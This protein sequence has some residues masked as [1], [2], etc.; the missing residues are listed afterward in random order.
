M[1]ETNKKNYFV[2][3]NVLIDSP[4]CI[5]QLRNG[6]ENNVYISHFVM[7]E[8]NKLAREPRVS[9]LVEKAIDEI[10]KNEEFIHFLQPVLEEE[11]HSIPSSLKD[12]LVDDLILKEIMIEIEKSK[13]PDPILVSNDRIFRRIA[14]TAG[15]RAEPFR[16]SNPF[17]SESETYT[18]LVNPDKG[19]ELI[20]NCFYWRE[21]K[22]YFHPAKGPDKRV[23]YKNEVWNIEPLNEYQNLA[24][25]I[26]LNEEIPIFSMQ[27]SAGY[28]KTFLALAAAFKLVFQDK[29]Y[30]K[31]II[32]KPYE[33]V[34]RSMGFLPGDDQEKMAPYIRNLRDLALKL[35]GIRP[36]NKAFIDPKAPDLEFNPRR[37]EILPLAYI[38]G[39][40]IDDAVFILD[41]IQNLSRQETRAILTRMGQNVKFFA[42]GDTNQ[43][44]N[45]YLNRDNNGLNWI[46]KLM[47][48]NKEYAH[49]V[50]K[51]AHSRG[52]ITDLTLRVG[53]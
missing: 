7:L 3:T 49:L 27:S 25:E 22:P 52:P 36:A 13:I 2:D 37:F 50:L 19:E 21:G 38:R 48:N 1:A 29:K 26:M 30:K 20:R 40:N 43:V 14:K 16:D 32:A 23:D 51:G 34:G 39:M 44:D 35:H 9:H 15:L 46:V 17:K 41:E 6:K 8:L 28:G 45:R 18:G 12:V 42:L 11:A 31:I 5:V 4:H 24:F 53:L 10:E 47:K 33:E